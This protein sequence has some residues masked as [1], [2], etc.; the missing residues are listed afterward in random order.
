MKN[1]I[2]CKKI[3]SMLKY[4]LEF[5]DCLTTFTFWLLMRDHWWIHHMF[6]THGS[7]KVL[8]IKFLFPFIANRTLH[9][10]AVYPLAIPFCTR[11]TKA[12][13]TS[14]RLQW[15]T[16]INRSHLGVRIPPW[17]HKLLWTAHPITPHTQC[18]N[19]SPPLHAPIQ[20]VHDQKL[21]NEYTSL[22]SNDFQIGIGTFP[23][24]VSRKW[25]LRFVRTCMFLSH[26]YISSILWLM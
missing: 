5:Q 15:L 9:V 3:Y 14:N 25:Q 8:H 7:L 13:D 2:G 16:T 10:Y 22:A 20:V 21:L 1:E 26:T 19:T 17:T 24:S 23:V 18:S 4:L 6:T 12:P 11:C